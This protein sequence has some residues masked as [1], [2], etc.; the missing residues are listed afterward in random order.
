MRSLPYAAPSTQHWLG[1]DALG[2]DYALALGKS[3]LFTVLDVASAAT[4]AVAIGALFAVIGS[5]A[6][7]FAGRFIFRLATVFSFA[8]PLIAVLLLLYSLL[9]DRAYL[10]AIV[11]GSL[12]WGNSALTLQTA[13]LERWNAPYML[14]AKA[15]GLPLLIRIMKCL[16]PALST[17]TR[18]AWVAN[19]P[20]ILS[21]SVLTA[22]LGAT[23]GALRLGS[24]LRTGYDVFPSVW[25][26][27]LPPTL[28]V[29]LLF[30]AAF[31]FIDALLNRN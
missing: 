6:R 18:A 23:A 1:T 24:L 22:Y 17:P 20:M 16:M 21:V 29:S 19:W 28:I 7:G 10:F 27:W 9:G 31:Q 14:A 3:T 15:Q 4:I 5:A 12:L 30:W 25:W 26:L 2:N 11:V 13:I 8:T